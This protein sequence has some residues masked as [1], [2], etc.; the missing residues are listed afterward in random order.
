M[1]ID[2]NGILDSKRLAISRALSFVEN[3]DNL[4]MAITDALFQHLGRAYR[5]GV[6]GPPG[7]GKSSLVDRIISYWRN[8]DKRI[9]VI[10]VDPTSPFTGGAILGDRVRMGRHYADKGV[11][12]RSM[13]TRGN[14]GGLALRAQDAAD[15]FDAAGF[16]IIVYETVGVGQVELDV[17]KAADTTLVVLVPE[18][19]DD[20]QAMKAGLMEIA[21]LFIINKSDRQG[22]NQAFAQIQSMLEMRHPEKGLWPP[23]VIKTSALK[24]EGITTLTDA[25]VEHRQYLNEHGIIRQNFRDRILFKIKSHIE[26]NVLHTFWSEERRKLLDQA[27]TTDSVKNILPGKIVDSLLKD[28]AKSPQV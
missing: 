16:D 6:T 20:I 14:H 2:F 3:T 18:S 21:D 27:M 15:I 11:F 23:Q 5:I 19:G 26:E 17:A 7:A 22:A 1:K 12:I 10:S 25:L 9:A 24:D 28:E 4:D 8:Q 13:A